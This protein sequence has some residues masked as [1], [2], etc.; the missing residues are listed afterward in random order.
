M[1]IDKKAIRN[2]VFFV[3]KMLCN[4]FEAI[5]NERCEH[6]QKKLSEITRGVKVPFTNCDTV[7][8][9][10]GILHDV[11]RKTPTSMRSNEGGGGV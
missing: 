3:E 9:D 8:R 4:G 5:L 1:N 10:F 7:E 11:S 2:H 6:C